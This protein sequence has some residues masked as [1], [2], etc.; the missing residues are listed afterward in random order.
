MGEFSAFPP[1]HSAVR[2]VVSGA[3]GGH[4]EES[5]SHNKGF[6]LSN[7]P[8]NKG[9]EGERKEGEGHGGRREVVVLPTSLPRS[10]HVLFTFVL[11]ALTSFPFALFQ[12]LLFSAFCLF[13]FLFPSSFSSFFLPLF[14]LFLSDRLGY[15]FFFL[16][17]G[18]F[19]Y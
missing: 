9:R 15:L 8:E 14:Y 5:F 17:L 18:F 6:K 11:A 1:R 10:I 3:R 2:L 19:F 4:P 16:S 13:F 12:F 7:K